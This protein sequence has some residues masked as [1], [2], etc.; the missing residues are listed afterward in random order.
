[1]SFS[2]SFFIAIVTIGGFCLHVIIDAFRARKRI[3]AE[4]MHGVQTRSAFLSKEEMLL[5]E[6]VVRQ[7]LLLWSV[8]AN[9]SRQLSHVEWKSLSGG[10]Y[11]AYRKWFVSRK[12]SYLLKGS[13]EDIPSPGV[14]LAALRILFM[15]H[16]CAT[17]P[18]LFV[19]QL[20]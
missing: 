15:S 8:I 16:R 9:Y 5:R 6:E 14:H 10:Y 12:F 1:V 7:Y 17:P 19:E 3:H 4:Y 11:E 18:E 2:E 13:N 20:S